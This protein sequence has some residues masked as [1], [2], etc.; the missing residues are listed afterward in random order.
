MTVLSADSTARVARLRMEFRDVRIA[1]IEA[2]GRFSASV[3]N[4]WT[5]DG[6]SLRGMTKLGDTPDEAVNELWTALTDPRALLV[7]DTCGT[8]EGRCELRWDSQ[9]SQWRSAAPMAAVFG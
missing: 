1:W 6:G 7:V 9:A 5:F 8:R 4:V 3:R 2:T